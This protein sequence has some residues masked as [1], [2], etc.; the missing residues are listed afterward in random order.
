ME[1]SNRKGN[2]RTHEEPQHLPGSPLTEGAFI[3][4]PG[5]EVPRGSTSLGGGSG[6]TPGGSGISREDS[7]GVLM[8]KQG[9]GRK[10]GLPCFQHHREILKQTTPG[11]DWTPACWVRTGGS[12]PSTFT[13]IC[14]NIYDETE[15]GG[16]P[17]TGVSRE[18]LAGEDCSLWTWIC[19]V[20][21]LSL[22]TH[23]Q[24]PVDVC[25]TTWLALLLGYM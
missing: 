10:E 23:L 22:E 16:W 24:K 15:A 14:I 7:T 18:D 5:P 2:T 21:S 19:F 20:R 1:T 13:S 12:P 17:P 4:D 25:I 3:Q 9:P 6:T 11:P 8:L